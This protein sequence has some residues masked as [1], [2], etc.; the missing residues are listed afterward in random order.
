[1]PRDAMA[2]VRVV[3]MLFEPRGSV[4]TREG[5]PGHIMDLMS[6]IA[7][8]CVDSLVSRAIG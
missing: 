6:L 8:Q 7:R 1:M 2:K 3:T 4:Q 5:T